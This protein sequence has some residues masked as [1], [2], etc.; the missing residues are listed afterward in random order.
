MK[1]TPQAHPIMK[2]TMNVKRAVDTTE[3]TI[4][5]VVISFIGLIILFPAAFRKIFK[6][7]HEYIKLE[8][9]G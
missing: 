1:Q 4:T 8:V 9:E 7:L 2:V 3:N 6:H 5:A